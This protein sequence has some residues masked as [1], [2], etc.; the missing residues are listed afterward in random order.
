M[1]EHHEHMRQEANHHFRN[2]SIVGALL[3]AAVVG[4]VFLIV[5]V[6]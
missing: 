5:S 3:V 6:I 4:V 2:A 1:I